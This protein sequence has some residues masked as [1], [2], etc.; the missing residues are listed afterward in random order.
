MGGCAWCG[1]HPLAHDGEGCLVDGCDCTHDASRDSED[2]RKLLHVDEVARAFGFKLRRFG[3]KQR[4]ASLEF[5]EFKRRYIDTG[6]LTV[7]NVGGYRYVNRE[8]AEALLGR[9]INFWS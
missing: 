8:Q 9:P 3:P 1:C 5:Y 2:T 7:I 6:R 4:G